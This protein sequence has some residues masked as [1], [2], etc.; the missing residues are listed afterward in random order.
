MPAEP[1]RLRRTH[2]APADLRGQPV[3]VTRADPGRRGVGQPGHEPRRLRLRRGRP[4]LQP[5]ADHAVGV[6]E[7]HVAGPDQRP[8]CRLRV[9]VRAGVGRP[10]VPVEEPAVVRAVVDAVEVPA[11]D[12]PVVGGQHDQRVVELVQVP[13]LVDDPPDLLVGHLRRPR[14]VGHRDRAT[15]VVGRSPHVCGLV[16]PRQAHEDPAPVLALLTHDL[17]R[18]VGGP[19][20]ATLV[21][22]VE[23]DRVAVAVERVEPRGRPVGVVGHGRVGVDVPAPALGRGQVARDV[24]ALGT[25]PVGLAVAVAVEVAAR[26]RDDAVRPAAAEPP[27]GVRLGAD[28]DD[29][30]ARSLGVQVVGELRVA[31]VLLELEELLAVELAGDPEGVRRVGRE[32]GQDAVD[33]AVALV[34]P[35][36]VLGQ[37]A[38][39]DDVVGD[40]GDRGGVAE[41]AARR[42]DAATHEPLHVAHVVLPDD[43]ARQAVHHDDDHP[44][45]RSAR[46]LCGTSRDR[47]AGLGPAAEERGGDGSRGEEGWGTAHGGLRECERRH[48]RVT[49]APR[50]SRHHPPI[51]PPG[52]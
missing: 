36:H 28:R 52:G 38:A 42:V 18:R 10:V 31:G 21:R 37:L 41:P 43:L 46:W 1:P 44:V 49:Q 33:V 47:G 22:R 8:Q 39:G 3:A 45:G 25:A 7:T 23:A 48:V 19:H 30:R 5:G 32:L 11:G 17:E 26:E 40:D 4:G 12:E 51:G 24:D 16:D 29:L 6:G 2:P 27:R 14:H 9:E 35:P 15:G 50:G 13:Q 20:V 34:G